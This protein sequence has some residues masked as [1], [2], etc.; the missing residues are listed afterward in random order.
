MKKASGSSEHNEPTEEE[1]V[2]ETPI[3]MVKKM[4]MRKT[5][6]LRVKGRGIQRGRRSEMR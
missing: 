1:D 5:R 4:M 2:P 6:K 3:E